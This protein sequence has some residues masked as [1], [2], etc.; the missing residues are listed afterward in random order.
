MSLPRV[1]K[2]ETITYN[3]DIHSDHPRTLHEPNELVWEIIESLEAIE[4]SKAKKK[5]FSSEDE[6]DIFAEVGRDYSVPVKRQRNLSSDQLVDGPRNGEFPSESKDLDSAN[7]IIDRIQAEA[8]NRKNAI[9]HKGKRSSKLEQLEGLTREDFLDSD[10]SEDEFVARKT[11]K[12]S[13]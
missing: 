6:I 4:E 1:R 13:G 3:Y 12:K 10:G 11:L 8:Q 7:A 2:K 9:L 5:Q